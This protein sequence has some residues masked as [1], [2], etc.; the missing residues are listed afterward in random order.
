METSLKICR[1]IRSDIYSRRITPPKCLVWCLPTVV[2]QL[3][4][5]LTGW[6]FGLLALPLWQIL[7]YI[8]VMANLMYMIVIT[9]FNLIQCCVQKVHGSAQFSDITFQW[10]NIFRRNCFVSLWPSQPLRLFSSY[11][12]LLSPILLQMI[13][14]IFSSRGSIVHLALWRKSRQLFWNSVQCHFSLAGE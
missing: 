10:K 12:F 3:G 9:N 5:N 7:S 14:S 2:S 4:F 11:F 13:L 8:F 1:L 6:I